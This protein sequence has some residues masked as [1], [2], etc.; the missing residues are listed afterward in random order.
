RRTG[1]AEGAWQD[2]AGGRAGAGVPAAEPGPAGRPAQGAGA[3]DAPACPRP[4]IRR[5][6]PRPR[7]DPPA[8]RGEPVGSARRRR[9]GSGAAGATKS[10]RTL[11]GAR[12]VRLQFA[13]LR[14]VSSA[15]EHYLDMVGVTGS[16]PVPPTTLVL[17]HGERAWQRNGER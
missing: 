2:E 8:A 6:R 3:E 9:C 16:N 7:P 5:R 4:R 11:V 10:I 12:F 15:V 13:P 1:R 17:R 14:A